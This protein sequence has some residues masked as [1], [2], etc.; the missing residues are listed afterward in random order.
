MDEQWLTQ[1]DDEI[2]NYYNCLASYEKINDF[3][4]VL[5]HH[6]EENMVYH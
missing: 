6:V 4:Q 1:T 5:A 2:S 3:I